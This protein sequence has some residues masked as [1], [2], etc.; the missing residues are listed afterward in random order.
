[1]SPTQAGHA[2]I[3]KKP[4]TACA[5]SMKDTAYLHAIGSSKDVDT[6]IICNSVEL[7]QKLSQQSS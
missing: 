6:F 5:F 4:L 7:Y 3:Y 1:M 2:N